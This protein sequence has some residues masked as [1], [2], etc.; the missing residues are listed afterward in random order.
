M[1]NIT[2]N[3]YKSI[4]LTS[5]ALIALQVSGQSLAKSYEL[6][7][8]NITK[9]I[10][11]TPLLA[12]THD[13]KVKLFTVGAAASDEV[14]RIAEGGDISGLKTLLS[15]S[16]HVRSTTSSEGLLAP[17]ESVTLTIDG[18]RRVNKLSIISMLLPTN[19]TLVA[20]RGAKLPKHRYGKVT[21]FLHAYDGGVETNDELCANI[22][23]PHCGGI[24][25][26]PEDEGEG[27]IYPSP[28]IHGEGDLFP[29]D[30]QWQ[31]AVA[32]VVVKRI[33]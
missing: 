7:I 16:T 27:Y 13:H 8:T 29:K 6:T 9:G 18:N 2:K 23:G 17:G 21:Y 28:A 32:K 11:F 30:Y 20:L 15:N 31:G 12:A 4:L 3:H 14:A 33:H 26:S 19:D 1:K 24:P 10:S 22:P 5:L 25:F